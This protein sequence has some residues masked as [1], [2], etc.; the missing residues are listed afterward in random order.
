MYIQDFTVLL[1]S[2]FCFQIQ[3]LH[4]CIWPDRFREIIHHDGETGGW[5]ERNHTTGERLWE[6]D[7]NS[8]TSCILSLVGL[9]NF[10]L[11]GERDKVLDLNFTSLFTPSIHSFLATS[12]F[13]RTLSVLTAKYKMQHCTNPDQFILFSFCQNIKFDAIFFWVPSHLS[14][15]LHQHPLPPPIPHS[16]YFFLINN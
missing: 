13:Y 5:P 8:N 16:H 15:P 1:V 4:L 7:K 9:C 11:S 10:M 3:H 2:C 6:W 12:T 14:A